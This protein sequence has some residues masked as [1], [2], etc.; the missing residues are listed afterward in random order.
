M[1][2]WQ[3]TTSFFCRSLI[4]SLVSKA[5]VHSAV[6]PPSSREHSRLVSY[7]DVRP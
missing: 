7:N 6:G 3:V 4:S 1:L 2:E 5:D